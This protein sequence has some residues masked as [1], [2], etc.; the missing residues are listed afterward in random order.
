MIT[1][2]KVTLV[3]GLYAEQAWSVE[4]ELDGSSTLDALHDVIQDAVGFENDHLYC[5][6]RSRTDRSQT[7]EYF[8]DENGL[9]WETKL[10]DMFPLPP[11]QSLFYLFD[12]GDEWVFKI[13]PSRKK[14]HEC[15]KGVEYP[16]VINESGTKPVQYPNPEE[17]DDE[18]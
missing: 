3:R 9:I 12:W 15:Q 1:T 14:S 5:F 17:E 13:S 6:Y 2:L 18:E 4:I 7:R 11:K 16:R 10:A 8:D